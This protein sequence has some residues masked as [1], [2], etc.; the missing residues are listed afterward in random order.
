MK[1]WEQYVRTPEVARG[2]AARR[3]VFCRLV[4]AH[5]VDSLRAIVEI[6][7]HCA[8]RACCAT[9]PV[10][11]VA[12]AVEPKKQLA[13]FDS[14][15]EIYH[16]LPTFAVGEARAVEPERLAVIDR[17]AENVNALLARASGAGLLQP[18]AHHP[19]IL[20]QCWL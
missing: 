18:A 16:A 9:N 6:G 11:M 8:R 10:T 15:V 4:A 19:T 1:I 2:G 17:L 5:V 13:V 12:A 20:T 14:L 7:A 3:A